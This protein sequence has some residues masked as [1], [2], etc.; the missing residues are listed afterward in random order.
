MNTKI[1]ASKLCKGLI[2]K[3]IIKLTVLVLCISSCG[4]VAAYADIYPYAY[5]Y[6]SP[7]LG[8]NYSNCNCN[9]YYPYC[10]NNGYY[11]NSY[12]YNYNC[13]NYNVQ[14]SNIVISLLLASDN[15]YPSYPYS[16]INYNYYYP[17][18]IHYP[19]NY[20]PPINYRFPNY[21]GNSPYYHSY[22]NYHPWENTIQGITPMPLTPPPGSL[23]APQTRFFKGIMPGTN[24]NAI[25]KQRQ[26]VP[27]TNPGLTTTPGKNQVNKPLTQTP[28]HGVKT[29]ALPQNSLKGPSSPNYRHPQNLYRS[30]SNIYR[31]PGNI[32]RH[33]GHMPAPIFMRPPLYHGHNNLPMQ[34]RPG[35]IMQSPS[36]IRPFMNMGPHGNP[37]MNMSR[38]AM[39]MMN[40]PHGGMPGGGMMGIPHIGGGGIR[41]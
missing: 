36:F 8:S 19:I 1:S 35:Q 18:N 21:W 2:L 4:L 13:P 40:M 30:P 33:P 5:G 17:Q 28:K 38:P 12:P 34:M 26:T 39:P 31:N 10:N 20:Y 14:I 32:Y 7:Y 9:A 29:P 24:P 3:R 37:T 22:N 16:P 27:P 41:R 25:L 6:S 23:G 15:F 11:N